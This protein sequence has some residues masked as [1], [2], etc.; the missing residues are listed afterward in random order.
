VALNH[1]GF[2]ANKELDVVS[3]IKKDILKLNTKD[4][5]WR[6]IKEIENELN[7][8][9][10]K[11]RL[12]WS[13]AIH[14]KMN[15]NNHQDQKST[16][17][18][19]SFLQK[20]N[21]VEKFNENDQV[22]DPDHQKSNTNFTNTTTMTLPS[23]YQINV[24]LENLKIAQSVRRHVS[25][26]NNLKTENVKTAFGDDLSLL[27]AN[28]VSLESAMRDLITETND[29]LTIKSEYID[30]D[31]DEGNEKSE[32][33]YYDENMDNYEKSNYELISI[34]KNRKPLIVPPST[35]PQTIVEEEDA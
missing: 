26:N 19:K 5:I 3:T 10:D 9:F 1:F 6:K 32:M 4:R 12:I 11:N 33:E 27:R 23:S 30:D 15:D 17:S 7:F 2:D 22:E 21:E 24:D 29:S 25:I 14:Q 13:D 31:E 8:D 35:I 16:N 34:N 20:L 28:P 18:R